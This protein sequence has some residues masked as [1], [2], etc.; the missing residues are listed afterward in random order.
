MYIKHVCLPTV[1]SYGLLT[2]AEPPGGILGVVLGRSVFDGRVDVFAGGVELTEDGLPITEDKLDDVGFV[3]EMGE[4]WIEVRRLVGEEDKIVLKVSKF[5]VEEDALVPFATEGAAADVGTA[6]EIVTLGGFVSSEP[7]SSSS[8]SAFVVYAPAASD[9]A[10]EPPLA[11]PF[12]VFGTCPPFPL[13]A[14]LLECAAFGCLQAPWSDMYR[15]IA[16]I[17][18]E[19][20]STSTRKVMSTSHLVRI[21]GEW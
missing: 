15:S 20:S 11:S 1:H 5:A 7:S 8:D 19:A 2:V 13:F 18:S 17:T 9:L 16:E 10:L 12:V 3:V 6:C 14:V 4:V 21:V